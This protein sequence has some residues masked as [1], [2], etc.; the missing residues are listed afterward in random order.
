MAAET[1]RAGALGF[2]AAGH[3]NSQTSLKEFEHEL[4][5][6]REQNKGSNYPLAI[7]FIGH[8]TFGCEEGKPHCR[9]YIHIQL[10]EPLVIGQGY[11]A[12]FYVR[13]QQYGHT[14]HDA[15]KCSST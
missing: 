7:G 9:E 5:I 12:E 8:S 2:L 11:Y 6:F 1:C 14:R 4:E 3:L 13:R 10:K 15:V